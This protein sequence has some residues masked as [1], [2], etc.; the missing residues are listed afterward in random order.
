MLRGQ[1]RDHG[2]RARVGRELLQRVGH[3]R[4]KAFVGV[5]EREAEL[6]RRLERGVGGAR[7]V[8]R[9]LHQLFD[10][11]APEGGECAALGASQ[12]HDHGRAVAEAVV[13]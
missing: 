2:A 11:I 4:D 9:P 1:K 7:V 8:E 3:T 10:E 6:G 13:E 12:H 5:S